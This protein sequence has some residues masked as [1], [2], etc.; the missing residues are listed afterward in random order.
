MSDIDDELRFHLETRADELVAEGKSASDAM[1]IAKREFGDLGRYRDD[2]LTVD[3][4]HMRQLRMH[5][6]LESVGGDL[7]SVELAE[8]SDIAIPEELGTVMRRE[9]RMIELSSRSGD[10]AVPRLLEFL[11]DNEIRA[12]SVSISRPTLDD[13]FLKYTKKRL[14]SGSFK[15]ARA[16]RRSFARHA[17]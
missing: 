14:D 5:E 9:G 13:V 12:N 4:Q 2:T 16:A 6:L 17:R 11:G 7:V 3:R 1:Q 8:D 10:R 15:E